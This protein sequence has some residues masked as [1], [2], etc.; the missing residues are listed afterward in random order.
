MDDAED[1]GGRVGALHVDHRVR[2]ASKH[3]ATPSTQP[4]N[5]RT[6]AG[7]HHGQVQRVEHGTH[8]IA[9]EAGALTLVAIERLAASAGGVMRNVTARRNAR[10]RELETSPHR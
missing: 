4:S 5:G 9:A 6:D 8:E 7:D 10:Q 3:Q 2:E 1:K